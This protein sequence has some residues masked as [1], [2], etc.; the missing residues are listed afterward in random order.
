MAGEVQSKRKPHAVVVPYPAQGHLNPVMQLAKQLAMRGFVITFVNTAEFHSRILQSQTTL[1]P[2]DPSLDIRYA[3]IP[4]GLPPNFNRFAGNLTA[5]SKA[6]ENMAPAFEDLIRNLLSTQPPVT[7]IFSDM[8]CLFTQDVA[9]KF[10]LPRIAIWLQSAASYSVSLHVPLLVR[11][12]H[13]PVTEKSKVLAAENM[14]TCIPAHPPLAP[15][16][17]PSFYQVEDLSDFMV[18]FKV[19]PFLRVKEAAFVLINSFYDLE[20]NMFDA[21]QR[22]HPVLA[23]GPFLPPAFL[24][25]QDSDDARTGTGLWPEDNE[26]LPWLDKQPPRSV[27]YI[28]FGSIVSMDSAQFLELAMGLEASQARL[29]WAIRPDFVESVAGVLPSRFLDRNKETVYLTSWAPQALVLSHTSV[30]GF[31][32]HCGWNSTL[33]GVSMGVPML[34]WPL[35]AEQWLNRKWIVEEWKIGMKFEEG[36]DGVVKRDEIERVVKELME[37]TQ[38][39]QMRERAVLLRDAGRKAVKL[40]GSSVTNLDMVVKS[41]PSPLT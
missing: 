29:L 37:G 16:E 38:G 21:L 14:I 33:E 6:V 26:C 22:D 34:G 35:F 39:Q 11:E 17:L 13:M 3:Q 10:E 40:G 30:G 25:A 8:F 28:S 5:L 18:Q 12:G 41:I 19:K 27:L 15:T 23:A 31:L 24:G 2:H 4:D 20:K 32:T 36:E 7:C 1:P 9:N